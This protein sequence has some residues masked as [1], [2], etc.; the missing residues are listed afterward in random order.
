MS[1]QKKIADKILEFNILFILY[2]EAKGAIKSYK[3]KYKLFYNVKNKMLLKSKYF[4]NI[5]R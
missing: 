2:V 4:T 5:K 3:I 1:R